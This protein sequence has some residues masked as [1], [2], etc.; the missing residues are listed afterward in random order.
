[1]RVEYGAADF[2]L[3]TTETT[4]TV[5]LTD[6]SRRV[7][8]DFGITTV[9]E[10]G[11]SRQ[12]S[13]RMLLPYDRVDLVQQRLAALRATA[14]LW[15]ADDTLAS[16][17]VNGFYKDFSLDLNTRPVSYCTLTIEGLTV[18]EPWADTGAD[19]AVDGVSSTFRFIRPVTVTEAVLTDSSVPET[20]YVAWSAVDSYATG[21]RA[22]KAH[23]VWESLV[24]SNHGNDPTIAGTTKWIDAGPTNRWA[25]FDEALGSY[26]TGTG[27]IIVNL[28]A[29]EA[30]QGLAVLDTNAD[31]V[32]VQA[33]GYD[34]T[35]PAT[36]ATISF[37]DLAVAA[38]ATITVTI[39]VDD[40]EGAVS[41]GTL[42]F[43]RLLGLGVTEASPTA[44]ITDYSKKET[45][46]FGAVTVVERAWAKRMDANALIATSAV[47]DVFSRVASVRA[48]PVLWI[49]DEGTDALTIYGFY[50]SFSIEISE[51]TS[52]LSLSVEGL[53]TA[54][55]VLPAIP[56]TVAWPD[57][58]DPDGTKP[59][60]GATNTRDPS[61]PVGT[62]GATVADLL[63]GS[64]V[65]DTDPPAVPTGLITDGGAVLQDGSIDLRFGWNANTESDFVYYVLA[66][67]LN[68]G[69]FIQFNAPSNSFTFHALAPN[70]PYEAKVRAVDRFGNS[71]AFSA[72]IS[73]NTTKDQQAPASPTGLTLLAGIGVAVI[74]WI[75][76]GDLDVATIRV[77]E[78]ETDQFADAVLVGTLNAEPGHAGGTIRSVP[79]GE[80][81]FYWVSAVDTSDN[82]SVK[83][84]PEAVTSAK[85]TGPDI[86]VDTALANLIIAET[87]I[88]TESFAAKVIESTDSLP[89][90]LTIDTTGF[91]LDTAAAGAAA[92][93][94]RV[95]N[96]D[97]PFGSGG[98]WY[99]GSTAG[100]P[101]D[102]Q[103]PGQAN[104]LRYLNTHWTN[105][106]GGSAVLVDSPRFQVTG[107]EHLSYQAALGGYDGIAGG[108]QRIG[109]VFEDG[110][111]A[112]MPGTEQY[113][114]PQA[115]GF[116]YP[117]V[118]GGFADVPVGAVR[119]YLHLVF[120]ASV[121]CS[122][123][124]TFANGMV[125]TARPG[126]T[127]L[128]PYQPGYDPD[129]ARAINAN[130]TMIGAGKIAIGGGNPL[131]S[132]L[133]G[134]DLT[135]INGG[136]IAADTIRLNSAVIGVRGIQTLDI[137]FDTDRVSGVSWSAGWVEWTDSNMQRRVDRMRGESAYLDP[138]N[139]LGI[140]F[141][142]FDSVNSPN[143]FGDG[144][145]RLYAGMPGGG[146]AEIMANPSN[147]ILASYMGG[148]RLNDYYGRTI[149]D[150]DRIK[151]GAITA[152]KANINALSALTANVG[153]LRTAGS[154]ARTEI[155]ANQ[156]R[157]YDANNVLRVLI[158]QW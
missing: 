137:T 100:V 111:G 149:I 112:Y 85:V 126:Q 65:I 25:M 67:A 144:T 139:P 40:Q 7:T 37:L 58:A 156:M 20:E 53:S 43:G 32:R 71:S 69:G 109:L 154:G 103:T 11:F 120:D 59:A 28:T 97:F 39:A 61:T 84:G 121:A 114:S 135:E 132:L 142:W 24:D 60:D 1:M 138:A 152:D 30:V 16:L 145:G 56:V 110:A 155:E 122:P 133:N 19:P 113:A 91:R 46:D 80:E 64:G 45:D 74:R 77:Y 115:G 89:G 147:V 151:T 75:A 81:R 123:G 23:R 47:D 148:Q 27:R 8:D 51:N 104:G 66:V 76:P 3:G 49:A 129:A 86:A 105:I 136:K 146:A 108:R 68:G 48:R 31:S 14:A 143:V 73:G 18:S 50:K 119:A 26:T 93:I 62:G 4:P 83:A 70:T 157:V 107:G 87:A 21:A 106:P 117:T 78:A 99:W 15:V 22:R 125:A 38:G 12:M 35:Q 33:P 41:A 102:E 54:T 150:S 88:V 96:S 10:R 2:D 72:P 134:G 98:G 29:A 5:T 63:A 9:V 52:K 94:N 158:G 153:L 140:V 116:A 128:P 13:V 141:V 36:A 92:G 34:R 118:V 44:A 95:P 17:S 6:Y 101:N 90:R 79:T 124:L 42:L 131:T 130:T 127:A 82:E 55:N 57:I